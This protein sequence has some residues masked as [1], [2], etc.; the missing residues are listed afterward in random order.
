M[1]ALPQNKR[2]D[3]PANWELSPWFI[4]MSGAMR[5]TNKWHIIIF[6]SKFRLGIIPI[7]CLFMI[8][9]SCN[10]ALA[11]W[12]MGVWWIIGI[13][14]PSLYA[15]TKDDTRRE[16][17]VM[18]SQVGMHTSSDCHKKTSFSS[19][20]S[21]IIWGTVLSPLI[22]TELRLLYCDPYM[23]PSARGLAS[24]GCGIGSYRWEPRLCCCIAFMVEPNN[25]TVIRIK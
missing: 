19:S 3:F 13:M 9:V 17:F 15:P 11:M 16:F 25:A 23:L 4:S 1:N 10:V 8:P 20:E 2:R 5:S 18:I 22:P 14:D 6:H 7:G 21:I 12:P 24:K